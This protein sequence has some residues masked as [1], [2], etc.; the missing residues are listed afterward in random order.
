MVTIV[1]P[2]VHKRY[3]S[4]GKE[5]PKPA[6]KA[7]RVPSKKGGFKVNQLYAAQGTPKAGTKARRRPTVAAGNSNSAKSSYDFR[8]SKRPKQDE[9]RPANYRKLLTAF[10][11]TVEH[12]SGP[13]QGEQ[14]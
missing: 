12:T 6:H 3:E 4:T 1:V 8:P 2:S 11:S 13:K 14:S 7:K 9:E 10:S 5:P